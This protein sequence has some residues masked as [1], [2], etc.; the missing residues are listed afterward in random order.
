MAKKAILV[1]DDDLSMLAALSEALSSCGYEVETAGNGVEAL[2]KF[3]AERFQLVITDLRMPKMGGMEVLREIKTSSPGTPVIV[4][5]AYGTVSTAVEAM[6]IG[7]SEFI[8]KPFSL[9]ELE[10]A[11]TNVLATTCEEEAGSRGPASAPDIITQDARIRSIMDMMKVVAKSKCTILIQGESGTGKELLAK[12]VYRQSNR[13]N[14]PFVAINCAAIPDNL[15]ESEMFGYEKGAFTGAN[16][17]KAGKFELA[18]GGTLLLDEISE[19]GMHLQ[20]KLLRVLQEGEVDR[21][22]GKAPLPV[23]VRIIATTNADL[24]LCVANKTFREDLFYRLN[25]IPIKVPALRDRKGDIPLL[26]DHLLR[27]VAA[28]NGKPLLGFDPRSLSLLEKSSWPGNIR[29]LKNTIERA[30]LMC[31]TNIIK[32][33]ELFLEQDS[34]HTGAVENTSLTSRPIKGS[35][36]KSMEAV[37]PENKTLWEMERSLILETLEKVNGNKT[38]ASKLLGIS[39]RTM[40]NKLNEYNRQ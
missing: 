30:I 5:T 12:F 36:G 13:R 35:D 23:D 9:D 10:G 6:K 19:M 32:P 14:M 40:R 11:V 17:R 8:M 26:S 21:L 15:L 31:S 7:A 27:E 18:D 1:V 16:Q 2:R 39:V 4:I 20:A 33:E 3:K 25:V 22:G 29:E 38:V 28:E 24:K 37:F 34:F